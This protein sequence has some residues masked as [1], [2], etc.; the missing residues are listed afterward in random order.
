MEP[1]SA[2]IWFRGNSQE[3]SLLIGVSGYSIGQARSALWEHQE[4]LLTYCCGKRK[5][6]LLRAG[7]ISSSP[8]T[9]AVSQGDSCSQ[10]TAALLAA[11]R[12]FLRDRLPV[13]PDIAAVTGSQVTRVATAEKG[14]R[15]SLSYQPG[16]AKV[17]QGRALKLFTKLPCYTLRHTL[18]GTLP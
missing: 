5:S 10:R 8:A 13:P 17:K 15:G 18:G 14:H 16:E 1:E 7:V 6:W 2:E 4:L 3:S 11:A 12:R 9:S